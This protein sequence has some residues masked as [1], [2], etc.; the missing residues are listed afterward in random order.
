MKMDDPGEESRDYMAQGRKVE[1]VQMGWP[2]LEMNGQ[3][4]WLCKQKKFRG[5]LA[6]STVHG[7]SHDVPTYKP[8]VAAY[9]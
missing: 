3:V 4:Y 6:F 2:S 7:A 8:V 1:A 9:L 5:N